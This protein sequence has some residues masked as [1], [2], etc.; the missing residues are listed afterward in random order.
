MSNLTGRPTDYNPKYCDE[1]VEF[2][3]QGKSI[4]AFA[5]SLSVARST[6]YEWASKHPEFSDAKRIAESKSE[7]WWEEKATEGMLGLISNFNATTLCFVMKNR[8]KWLAENKREISFSEAEAEKMSTDD[9][10]KEAKNLVGKIE[11]NE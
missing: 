4:T 8:F 6:I 7:A 1:I 10:I 11:S 5:A 9:L 2:M 3:S